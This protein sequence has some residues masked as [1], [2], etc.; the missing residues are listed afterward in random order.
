M[1][2]YKMANLNVNP[3]TSYPIWVC[4]KCLMLDK[5]K[6]CDVLE[7]MVTDGPCEE[8]GKYDE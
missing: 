4:E 7:Q 6:Q 5:Y 1:V 2:I 3:E 8:C